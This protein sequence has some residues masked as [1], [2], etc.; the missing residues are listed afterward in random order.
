MVKVNYEKQSS[1]PPTLATRL[2]GRYA[3]D[4]FERRR[5]DD[6]SQPEVEALTN[7][8]DVEP[9]ESRSGCFQWSPSPMLWHKGESLAYKQD[10]D[11]LISR[12][13]EHG[14]PTDLDPAVRQAALLN[15]LST[16]ARLIQH[17]FEC[18]QDLIDKQTDIPAD[19][20]NILYKA[21]DGFATQ[22]ELVSLIQGTQLVSIELAKLT[23]PFGQR[24]EHLDT[25]GQLIE[26][27]VVENGGMLYDGEET[28]SP[29]IKISHHQ[30]YTSHFI[31]TSKVIVGEVDDV[32]IAKRT[33]SMILARADLQF[34]PAVIKKMKQ[35]ASQDD[36]QKWYEQVFGRS[37][38][39][40][41][42]EDV[43]NN[44]DTDTE[45]PA[46][47]L[48]LSTVYYGYREGVRKGKKRA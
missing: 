48:P 43:Y 21:R 9:C 3:I 30:K 40:E 5:H 2:R 14:G 1:K 20:A 22:T 41:F 38:V 27:A 8:Y 42:I 24:A 47:I 10:I 18:Y 46:F 36:P 39:K 15:Y 12:A 17:N 16:D 6:E 26:A 4:L 28:Q 35:Y 37:G 19:L 32:V 33:A 45:Q 29:R 34:D 7:T 11:T 44:K 23:H 31:A 25:M 13:I